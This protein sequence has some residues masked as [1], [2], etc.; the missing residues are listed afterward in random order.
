MP[1]ENPENEHEPNLDAVPIEGAQPEGEL[2]PDPAEPPAIRRVNRELARLQT[3]VDFDY[4]NQMHRGDATTAGIEEE[5][6]PDES[7]PQGER[8]RRPQMRY[9]N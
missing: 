9:R 3:T 6:E 4:F 1:E 7:A 8:C 5:E 2:I